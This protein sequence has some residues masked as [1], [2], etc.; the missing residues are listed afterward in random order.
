[1]ED[2][3]AV[4]DL[5]DHFQMVTSEE[6]PLAVQVTPYANEEVNPQV[7]EQSLDRIVVEDFSDTDYDYTIAFTVKGVRKGFEDKEIILDD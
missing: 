3:R 5:P 2:G 1:M 4:I 6:E 7:V